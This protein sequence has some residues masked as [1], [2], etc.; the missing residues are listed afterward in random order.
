MIMTIT[1]GDG[2]Y[3]RQTL[4]EGSGAEVCHSLGPTA[5][6]LDLPSG[7]WW[8]MLFIDIPQIWL[9]LDDFLQE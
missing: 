2:A 8:E 7:I 9:E 6:G 1:Q 5:D 4:N 3:S